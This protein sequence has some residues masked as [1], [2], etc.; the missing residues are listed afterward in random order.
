MG[1]NGKYKAGDTT[2]KPGYS[3]SGVNVKASREFPGGTTTSI[4][5]DIDPYKGHPMDAQ[6][7]VSKQVNDNTKVY[8]KVTVNDQKPTVEIGF[9][10]TL[11]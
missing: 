8:G 1:D 6:Y 9:K 5:R 7:K 4:K 10:K 3:P 11:K 2:L